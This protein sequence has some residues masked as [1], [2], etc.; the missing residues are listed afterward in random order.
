MNTPTIKLNQQYSYNIKQVLFATQMD[1]EELGHLIM[2]TADTWLRRFFKGKIDHYAVLNNDAFM[3]WWKMHWFDRDDRFFIAEVYA[4]P[5][6]FRFAKYRQLHQMVF[7]LLQPTTQ[8]MYQD[9]LDM[10]S[11]FERLPVTAH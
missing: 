5:E 9:F 11:A 6:D 10:K 7:F 1:N 8:Y 3:K 2:E 4:A